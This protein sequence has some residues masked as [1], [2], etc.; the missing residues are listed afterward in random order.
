MFWSLLPS[1]FNL[2]KIPPHYANFFS[3]F[4]LCLPLKHFFSV[5][6][7]ISMFPYVSFDL[8]HMCILAAV[9][10]SHNT[11]G[12]KE[13]SLYLCRAQEKRAAAEQNSGSIVLFDSKCTLFC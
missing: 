4:S 3:A 8:N 1:I 7:I 12:H 6:S 10:Q 5:F 13:A 11:A 9:E 2:K